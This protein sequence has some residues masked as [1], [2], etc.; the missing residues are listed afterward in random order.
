MQLDFSGG[1]TMARVPFDGYLLACAMRAAF[2]GALRQRPGVW[3]SPVRFFPA[4][5]PFPLPTGQDSSYPY[6]KLGEDPNFQP[7]HG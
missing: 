2:F 6:A 1:G 4:A 5:V 7:R 3:P